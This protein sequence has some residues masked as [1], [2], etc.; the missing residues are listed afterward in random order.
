MLDEIIL[1][2]INNKILKIVS[3][4]FGL[5]RPRSPDCILN[6]SSYK[7]TIEERNALYRGLKNHILPKR[8]DSDKIK[9]NV[10]SLVKKCFDGK[11]NLPYNLKCKLN[12]IPDHKCKQ[13]CNTK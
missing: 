11:E 9:V 10:E 12:E 5:Q 3:T 8:I 7:L 1:L 6:L 13:I 2:Y 4:L